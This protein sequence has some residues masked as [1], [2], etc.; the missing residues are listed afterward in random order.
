MT[1]PKNTPSNTG[2]H[3][4]SNPNDLLM[5]ATEQEWLIIGCAVLAIAFGILN[6]CL[7]LKVPVLKR[8]DS[9]GN[10]I[11]EESSAIVADLS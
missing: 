2:V 6:I 5:S 8:V 9:S 3:Q 7:V 1:A 10:E 4:A 11:D